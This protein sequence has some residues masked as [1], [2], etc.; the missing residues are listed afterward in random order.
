MDEIIYGIHAVKSALNYTDAASAAT[1]VN[2]IWVDKSRKDKRILALIELA[3]S[4]SVTIQYVPRKTL[5]E[6][7]RKS[8]AHSKDPFNH[9]GIVAQSS[10]P[11]VKNENDLDELLQN[12]D[13]APFLLVLDGVQDPHNLG[14][15]IRSADAAGVHAVIAPKERAASMTPTVRKVACGAEQSTPFIQVTNLSRTLK[16]LK[17]YNIWII[18]TTGAT[19]ATIYNTDLSGSVALVMGAEGTGMRRLTQEQCDLL[20]KIPMAGSVESLNV[21]VATGVCLFETVR[22]RAN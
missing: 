12:L 16:L 13:E 11:Q 17:T 8:K 10:A 22:Q 15:C 14:A 4:K 21:S 19:D 2:L 5:D 6:Q 1:P 9:Q 3:K 18:G 20:V 7:S